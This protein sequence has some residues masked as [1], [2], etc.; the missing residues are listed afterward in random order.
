MA[1]DERVRP[2]GQCRQ[3]RPE[4]RRAGHHRLGRLLD[5]RPPDLVHRGEI[6]LWPGVLQFRARR[7]D[8]AGERVALAHDRVDNDRQCERAGQ[9]CGG[10]QGAG[11]GRCDD[12]RDRL[13][14]SARAASAAWAWPRSVSLGSTI[15]GSRRV[16]EKCRLNSLWPWRSR[17][18]RAAIQAA[19]RA[20]NPGTIAPRRLSFVSRPGAAYLSC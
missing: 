16:T 3:F 2:V 17:I 7:A 6:V 11:I 13:L 12:P 18:M 20:C 9:W 15:P 10:L 1:D 19:S 4:Q 14:G 5:R 8:V